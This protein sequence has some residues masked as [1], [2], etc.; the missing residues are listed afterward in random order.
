MVERCCSL[1]RRFADQLSAADGIEV[2][3]DVVLNQVLVRFHPPGGGDP[4]AHTRA[5]VARVQA[6]GICWLGGTTWQGRAA[7]RI[8][9]SSWATTEADVDRAAE[10]ILS[11]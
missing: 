6:D 2:L 4:D 11:A 9:I 5:V 8:S 7:A 10:A 3:N 1:A